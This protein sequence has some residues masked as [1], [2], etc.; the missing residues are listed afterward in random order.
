M[1][2][3]VAGPNSL[4]PQIWALLLPVPL[5]PLHPGFRRVISLPFTSLAKWT[6]G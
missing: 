3:P 1:S 2:A 6:A 5:I 4:S